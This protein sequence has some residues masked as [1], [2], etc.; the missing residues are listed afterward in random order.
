MVKKYITEIYYRD[1]KLFERLFLSSS[2][3]CE[4]TLKDIEKF[5]LDEIEISIPK[6]EKLWELKKIKNRYKF[7]SSVNIFPISISK[8]ECI[9]LFLDKP[10][11]SQ[12]KSTERE[13]E[14]VFNTYIFRQQF[15][16]HIF[17]LDILIPQLFKE[18]KEKLKI[19]DLCAG[20]GSYAL[21]VA[22]KYETYI[23]H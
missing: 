3:S 1:K 12:S 14:P 19:L 4:I 18:K 15:F 9:F 20:A 2:K 7:F 10:V 23:R 16:Q 21:Y 22:K 11:I 13:F 6:R 17:L 8:D 5:R